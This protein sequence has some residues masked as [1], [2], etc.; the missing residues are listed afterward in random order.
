M[1][2]LRTTFL[3]VQ[4]MFDDRPRGALPFRA[5]GK[6][7]VIGVLGGWLDERGGVVKAAKQTARLLA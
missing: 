5:L 2:K 3:A 7:P 6:V 1:W 4:G